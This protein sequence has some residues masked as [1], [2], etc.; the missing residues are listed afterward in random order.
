MTKHVK[1]TR[2]RPLRIILAGLMLASCG[3]ASGPSRTDAAGTYMMTSLTFDAQGVL[4]AVD[5]LA[6]L[7]GDVPRLVLAP[8]G[9]A[10]LVFEDPVTGLITTS[11][12]AYSTPDDGVRV[13]FGS[14][15]AFRSVLLS[16]RMTFDANS[17]GT[18]TFDATA[19]DGVDRDRL[20]ELVPEIANE[21]LLDPVPGQLTLVFT[22]SQ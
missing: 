7:D 12:G 8:A 4:P 15:T 21:Q 20:I 9:E 16:R 22:R 19:P 13:D 2:M 3:D 18:L 6:R 10:Q 11:N 14:G 17:E 5:V 1:E